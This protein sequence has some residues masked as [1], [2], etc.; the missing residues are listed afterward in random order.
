MVL[1]NPLGLPALTTPSVV[2]AAMYGELV[3]S[4]VLRDDGT[5]GEPGVVI[6]VNGKLSADHQYVSAVAVLRRYPSATAWVADWAARPALGCRRDRDG[7]G[8]S[9]PA[10]SSVPTPGQT[11]TK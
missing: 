4:A 5:L 2:V 1:S 3:W 10:V 6:E 7:A 9:L 11:V 8:R